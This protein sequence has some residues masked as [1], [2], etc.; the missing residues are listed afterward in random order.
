MR[1]ACLGDGHWR[2]AEVRDKEIPQ[3][4][5]ANSKPLRKGLNT[6]FIKC[7]F[8]DQSQCSRNRRRR[9]G[10]SRRSRRSLRPAA[11]TRPVSGLS[12]GSRGGIIVDV[13]FFRGRGRADRTAVDGSRL[14]G[15]EEPPVEARIASLAGSLAGF[16]IEL[17][18]STITAAAWQY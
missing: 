10:P 12:S 17:H 3:M 7:A 6:I 18:T 15:N 8:P 13:L 9:S 16:A 5:G 2:R 1:A 14:D 4:P 11:Q